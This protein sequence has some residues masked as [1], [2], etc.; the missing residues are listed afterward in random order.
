MISSGPFTH[1]IVSYFL[2]FNIFLSHF[3]TWL[4]CLLATLNSHQLSI[5]VYVSSWCF[6]LIYAFWASFHLLFYFILCTWSISFFIHLLNYL[7]LPFRIDSITELNWTTICFSQANNRD[8][9]F[10][11]IT[12]YLKII[13]LILQDHIGKNPKNKTINSHII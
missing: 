6:Y 10:A 4:Y 8:Y 1:Y 11:Y 2:R 5:V 13:F 9:I 7:Y 12:V 3:K